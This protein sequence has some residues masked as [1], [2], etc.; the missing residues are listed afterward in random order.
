[1][2]FGGCTCFSPEPCYAISLSWRRSEEGTELFDRWGHGGRVAEVDE[3]I[4]VRDRAEEAETER[5]PSPRSEVQPADSPAVQTVQLAQFSRWL[6]LLAFGFALLEGAAFLAF[7]DT[8]T[9]VTSAVLFG[10]GWVALVVWMLARQ[11]RHQ[12][13]VIL[14]CTAFLGGN[15]CRSISPA[16]PHSDSRPQRAVVRRRGALL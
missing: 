12:R 14:L 9:G 8:G 16:E 6:V 3:G 2:P 4:R 13:A 1:M 11:D 5:R 15:S 7:R 10:F